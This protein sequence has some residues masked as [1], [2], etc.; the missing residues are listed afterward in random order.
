VWIAKTRKDEWWSGEWGWFTHNES[1]R[2]CPIT[3]TM[4][5]RMHGHFPFLFFFPELEDTALRAFRH[6][7]NEDGEIA[8]SFGERTSMR[9]VKYHCQHPLNAGYYVQ[10]VLHLYQR[11]GDKEKLKEYYDSLK[12]AVR[13]HYT[14]DDD[15]DGLVNDQPHV[16]PGELWPANQFYD[17]W[18]WWGTS[19]YVA[20]IW[21]ATLKAAISAATLVEDKEFAAE[22]EKA[23]DQ[24]IKA[25]DKKLWKGSYY[26]LWA[27]PEA[28]E[29]CDVSLG[30]QLIAEWCASIT[31]AGPV[32]DEKKAKSALDTVWKLNV[33][34]TSFGMVNGVTEEG[35][36]FNSKKFEQS[37]AK[38]AAVLTVWNVDDNND[39]SSQIFIG[40]NFAAAMTFLYK[41]RTEEGLEIGKRLYETIALNS[42]TPWDQF[43]LYDSSSGLPVWGHDYYSNMIQ[44][45]L[46]VALE[47]KSL[48]QYFKDP[49]NLISRIV[50]AGR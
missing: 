46:P 2:G 49:K 40:E 4:V 6:F 17:I 28:K 5:C 24:G 25:F 34:A 14:L 36:R 11:T 26:R 29:N 18:P 35:E 44:W 33:G 41:G 43:C 30:N 16:L 27:N 10:Q 1:H 32:V 3:E 42:R 23:F 7:Q 38:D 48:E 45:L 12:R 47:G 31:G 8:F 20:G 22:C 50:A 9:D 39:H 19:V 15:N 37:R 21:L 13:Y